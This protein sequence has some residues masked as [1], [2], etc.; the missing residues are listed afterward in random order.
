MG[1]REAGHHQHYSKEDLQE[2]VDG[3]NE[4]RRQVEPCLAGHC[5]MRWWGRGRL[6]GGVEWRRG[7][8]S[9]SWR[10]TGVAMSREEEAE[11]KEVGVDVDVAWWDSEKG[12]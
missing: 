11:K 12:G 2:Q 4:H 1:D 6:G 7:E 3:V 10:R 9:S 5:R 8:S